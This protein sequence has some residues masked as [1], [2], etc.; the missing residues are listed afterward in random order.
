MMNPDIQAYLL[1][2][3]KTLRDEIGSLGKDMRTI[4][5]YSILALGWIWSWLILN[6]SNDRIDILRFLPA[7]IVLVI[8]FF[9]KSIG[10]DIR[11]IGGYLH[12]VE[13]FFS[14]PAGIGWEN[15][16]SQN[17][18]AKSRKFL[19]YA[20]WA[21]LLIANIVAGFYLKK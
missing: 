2:E 5:T 18:W 12:K 1:A 16:L 11:M 14:L 8:F 13:L 9:T 21:I 17:R 7:L 15:H 4:S 10:R 20:Y 19:E 3:Y 6:L